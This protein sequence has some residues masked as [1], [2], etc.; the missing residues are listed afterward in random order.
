MWDKGCWDRERAG[1]GRGG[2]GWDTD[3]GSMLFGMGRGGRHR[4]GGR[5]FEQ[6]DLKFVILQ[7]LEEKPRLGYDIIK[8]L[9][10]RS[11]GR[12]TP[13]AGTVYPT[14]T[15]L[16]DMGYA[17]ATAEPGGKKV[18]SITDEG[19]KYLA[20]NQS[21]VDD[22]LGRLGELGD[23]IFG[24]AVRPAHEAMGS[25]G[26]AYWRATLRQ[27]ASPETITKV[28]EILRKAAADIEALVKMP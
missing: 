17:T 20:E 22:I 15:L 16:E 24:D 9:E 7:M 25:L 6:G 14:L 27:Q 4:R 26:R 28:T 19:R 23:S 5:M 2:W 3:F 11:G 21:T 10:E 1:A 18:Y 13:S 12:Y 8:D